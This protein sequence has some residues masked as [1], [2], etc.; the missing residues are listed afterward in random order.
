VDIQNIIELK[1]LNVDHIF[2][3]DSTNNYSIKN[4]LESDNSYLNSI[5]PNS[6][7][8]LVGDF[9]FV[10]ISAFIFL[11]KK[12]CIVVPLTKSNEMQHM[13]LW[14]TAN[15]EF[16]VDSK[17][18][19]NTNIGVSNS[20]I[21]NQ[22]S[23]GE[24]GLILFSSGTS[25]EPKAI[26]HSSKRFFK[27]FEE[28]RIPYTTLAF[29][30][31]DH[32]GGLNTFFHTMFNQGVII[33]TISR[34]PK[35]IFKLMRSFN[36]ELLPTTPTFLRMSLFNQLPW[37]ELTK[38]KV[39]TYGTEIMTQTTL[40]A[41]CELLP[42]VDFK[43]TYGMS[44]IGILKIK[45]ESRG[46]LFMKIS[47]EGV[48]TRIREDILEIKSESSMIGYL[49]FKNPFDNFGWFNTR[50]K[51]E[52]KGEY[53]KILGREDEVINSGGLKYFP[54]EVEEIALRFPGIELV[55]VK[56]VENPLTGMHAELDAQVSD[57]SFPK[58]EFK[59]YLKTILPAY[60]YPAKININK[61]T[62]NRRFK[63]S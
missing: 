34:E 50:D 15:V 24:G 20:L 30:L 14:K 32:I 33:R 62:I 1:N 7:V 43:Q 59:K 45:S 10:T 55:K 31:F 37:K 60:M 23:S 21:L 41:L 8:A 63:R 42:S 17:S 28:S 38:L 56:K 18:V 49:N 54:R 25:G 5:K 46:S 29:L 36:V 11:L 39:I 16:V 44:E 2:F 53:V 13:H 22:K 51:V 4:L 61:I 6:V 3:K 9:D 57:L 26:F 52:Q 35:K 19:L 12:N 47:G 48:K 40:N 27:K 58:D